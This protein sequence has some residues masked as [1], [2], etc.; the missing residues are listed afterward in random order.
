MSIPPGRGRLSDTRCRCRMRRPPRGWVRTRRKETALGSGATPPATLGLV[1]SHGARLRPCVRPIRRRSLH[2]FS[3]SRGRTCCRDRSLSRR[4]SFPSSVPRP[5]R[6]RPTQTP[7]PAKHYASNGASGAAFGSEV[8]VHDDVAVVA[9]PG[10]QNGN[11]TG[12]VFRRGSGNAWSEEQALVTQP[13]RNLP[14]IVTRP[15][16]DHDVVAIGWPY[17]G[18]I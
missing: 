4:S 13:V 18:G 16:I 5:C 10:A 11:G 3:T 14:D 17:A 15:D 6:S 8:A 2:L 7:L 12:Y 9:A 1:V